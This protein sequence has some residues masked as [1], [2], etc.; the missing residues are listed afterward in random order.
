[1]FS[2]FKQNV[3]K[4][5]LKRANRS[6]SGDIVLTTFLGVFGIFSIWPFIFIISNAFKPMNEIFLFPP[7]LFVRNPTLNNFRDLAI[8][9]SDSWIPFSRYIFNTG[10]LTVLG[11]VGTVILSSM[12]AFPLAKYKFPGSKVMS[13]LI[14]YSLMFSGVVV[15]IPNYI[16]VSRLGIIDSYWSIVLPAMGGTLGLFLMKNFMEQ[17]PDTLLEAAKIDGASEYR[18]FWS[19]VMPSC[20]PAW[21]TLIIF[22]FQALWGET[23]GMFIYTEKL[24]PVNHV[25]SQIIG[26]GIARTGVASAVSLIMLIVPVIVFVVTQSNVIETMTTSGIKG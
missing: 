16:I 19:I 24:K 18:I 3:S 11:T 5:K 15:A 1:M 12:A 25:L 2:K 20:K 21:I 17:I 6:L 14:V 13:D 8:I 22:S 26:G 7:K 10:F 23:G 4:R 9:I